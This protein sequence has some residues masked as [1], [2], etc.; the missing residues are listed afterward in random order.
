M[1]PEAPPGRYPSK[2]VP[3]QH[4]AAMLIDQLACAHPAGASFTPEFLHAAG[5]RE[6]AAQPFAAAQPRVCPAPASAP[7][8]ITATPIK[9]LDIVHQRRPA[10]KPD[11][12]HKRRAMARK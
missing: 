8:V 9:R 5:H 12:R 3:R 7:P 11:L 4:P 2:A 10:K 6:A 1:P